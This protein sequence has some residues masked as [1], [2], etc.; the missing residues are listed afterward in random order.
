MVNIIKTKFMKMVLAI[1]LLIINGCGGDDNSSETNETSQPNS[2]SVRLERI[3]ISPATKQTKGTSEWIL[4]KGNIQRFKAIGIYSNNEQKEITELVNW[5]SNSKSITINQQGEALANLEGEAEISASLDEVNSNVFP[6]RVSSAVLTQLQLTPTSV[7]L[8]KGFRQPLKLLGTYSDETQALLSQN[9][10]WRVEDPEVASINDALELEGLKEGKTQVVATID[11]IDSNA[12]TIT[13]ND[14]SLTSLNVRAKRE[15][16]AVG[17]RTTVSAIGLF[18]DGSQK[19][20]TNVVTWKASHPSRITS[21]KEDGHILAQQEGIVSLHAHHQGIKS[22][23]LTFDIKPAYIS[24]LTIYPQNPSYPKGVSARITVIATYSN[25]PTETVSDQVEWIIENS[26]VISFNKYGSLVTLKEGT[27]TLQAKLNDVLS[28]PVTVE[29]GV[30]VPT[31]LL[32][33]P[34]ELTLPIGTKSL[35]EMHARYSDGREA[36]LGNKVSWHSTDTDVAIVDTYGRIEG[37]NSGKTTVYATYDEIESNH[38]EVEVT[39]AKP[40]TLL[41]SPLSFILPIGEIKRFEATVHFDDQTKL[42]MDDRGTYTDGEK[43]PKVHD[44]TW[45]STNPAIATIDKN[46]GVLRAISAGKT[47]IAATY[48]GLTSANIPITVSD[49]TLTSL[50]LEPSGTV[51]VSIGWGHGFFAKGKYSD[52]R[53]Y[54]LRNIQ[55]HSS[56]AQIGQFG[57]HGRANSIVGIAEGETVVHAT[58]G[59]IA[60]NKTT[61]KVLPA[62]EHNITISPNPVGSINL[63][64]SLQLIATGWF[65]DKTR[66]DLTELVDWSSSNSKIARISSS[67]LVTG[68]IPGSSTIRASSKDF[69]F[70]YGQVNVEVTATTLKKL[71]IEPI[72]NTLPIGYQGQLKVTGHYSDNTTEDVTQAVIWSYSM[73]NH[74]DTV[75]SVSADGEFITLN[76]GE[77]KIYARFKDLL[78]DPI[79]ISVK[80]DVV[81]DSIKISSPLSTNILA[82]NAKVKLEAIGVYSDGSR[83]SVTESVSWSSS[84]NQVATVNDKGQVQALGV[85][86]TSITAT[87]A[88]QPTVV[89]EPL[90]LEVEQ[91]IM[92]DIVITPT[93]PVEMELGRSSSFH[94]SAVFEHGPNVDVTAQVTWATSN[95]KASVSNKLMHKGL[96][97]AD[98]EGEVE[99]T[100]TLNGLKSKPVKITVVKPRTCTSIPTPGGGSGIICSM[101]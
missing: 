83:N 64:Q 50:Y 31:Q 24:K 45:E 80:D 62:V 43:I 65:G 11:N 37:L 86:R 53:I 60:S 38:L 95:S 85:G 77:A 3:Q 42:T 40:T 97:S 71:V 18:E 98:E 49:A 101:E 79:S 25:G 23:V 82:K 54:N 15:D 69:R 84:D 46:T 93:G 32:L 17:Y 96:V 74:K 34:Y 59:N 4:A 63:A 13:I 57:L 61:V 7:A 5:R 9:V 26:N 94:A 100:A 58:K 6:L 47:H 75:L 51:E 52:N 87:T 22:N 28:E 21:V 72:T 91:L 29:V 16:L 2:P 39:E 78:S 99:L 44:V 1:A 56:N 55:W 14:A 89:S 27:S 67:G 19:D 12:I 8:A 30:G 66:H 36:F 68:L 81:L 41:V 73:E 90:D 70:I 48:K 35:L 33:Q 20:L 88:I 76:S 10:S 92:T